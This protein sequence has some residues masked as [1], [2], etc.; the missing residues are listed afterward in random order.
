M[1]YHTSE[2]RKF[3]NEVLVKVGVPENEAD[4]ITTTMIEADA[5]GIHS[6]GLM[7][8]PIYIERMQKGYVKKEAVITVETDRRGMA[9]LDGNFSAGQIAATKAMDMAIEKA[10]EYGIS[11]VS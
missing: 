7:R 9:V 5:R 8:L 4:I 11:A 1:D 10:H 6:H 2:L 3:S